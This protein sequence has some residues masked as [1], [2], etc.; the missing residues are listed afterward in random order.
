[1]DIVGGINVSMP[2]SETHDEWLPIRV[3]PV[4]SRLRYG[5][6]IGIGKPNR[7]RFATL[8]LANDHRAEIHD[9][10]RL[11]PL[12]R[13]SCINLLTRKQTEMD[14]ISRI[15]SLRPTI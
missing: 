8:I 4:W 6:R 13:V 15:T 9:G 5:R 11:P 1:M 7:V 10:M 14:D 2:T 12:R 3:G